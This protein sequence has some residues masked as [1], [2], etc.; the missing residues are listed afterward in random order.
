MKFYSLA[1]SGEDQQLND[2]F[3]KARGIGNVSVG[4]RN[5]F[6][7]KLLKIYYIPYTDI[8]R[9]FRRVREAPAKLGC[10]SGSFYTESLVIY[11]DQGEA[12]EIPLPDTRAAKAL[13]EEL[14]AKT[15]Q[16]IFACPPKA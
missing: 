12:A 14:K 6:F 15:P 9:C 16:V 3:Q 4:S 13:I 7:R 10:C 2:D 11:T 5:L 8:R 1:S